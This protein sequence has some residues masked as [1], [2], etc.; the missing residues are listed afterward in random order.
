[1]S[2]ENL[3]L[4]NTYI[5]KCRYKQLNVH[6]ICRKRK[7]HFPFT[8]RETLLGWGRGGRG[9]A[10]VHFPYY[11]KV[12]LFFCFFVI[13]IWD[14]YFKK[15]CSKKQEGFT[16]AV[17]LSNLIIFIYLFNKL[18][19][20]RIENVEWGQRR[21]WEGFSNPY[22]DDDYM[23]KNM[24]E[25]VGIKEKDFRMQIQLNSQQYQNPSASAAAPSDAVLHF[26]K[27]QSI[28]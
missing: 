26:F 18:N 7:E 14:P 16:C 13:I 11:K 6:N 2:N 24:E 23:Q 20:A 8:T 4:W 22:S 1:M 28:P 3:S 12:K 17:F 9:W 21:I 5:I 19:R 10:V 15:G 27:V 25:K